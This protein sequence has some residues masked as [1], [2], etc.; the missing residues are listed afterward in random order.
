MPAHCILGG[1]LPRTP[2][3]VGLFF[4]ECFCPARTETEACEEDLSAAPG[5]LEYRRLD[6]APTGGER[7]VAL[8]GC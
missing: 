1:V 3:R 5:L 4:L 8:T 6:A 7:L 2:A